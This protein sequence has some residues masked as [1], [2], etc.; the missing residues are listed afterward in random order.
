MSVAV[1]LKSLLA[2]KTK[3]PMQLNAAA[4]A[5]P[6]KPVSE[7]NE[8]ALQVLH[9]SGI[10][11]EHLETR[12]LYNDD[13]PGIPQVL[14]MLNFIELYWAPSMIMNIITCKGTFCYTFLEMILLMPTKA[15]SSKLPNVVS[16]VISFMY[17]NAS[18]VE[19]IMLVDPPDL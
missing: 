10:T 2:E 19:S 3:G 11:P 6:I 16:D 5:I 1:K 7:R 18:Y 9:Q 13:C 12:T 14:T 8:L 17:L 15:P 4:D